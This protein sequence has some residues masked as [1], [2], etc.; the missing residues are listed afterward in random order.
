MPLLTYHML[1]R[2]NPFGLAQILRE[3]RR[4]GPCARGALASKHGADAVDDVLHGER[5]EQHAQ[6]T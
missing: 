2:L 3:H 6:Q 4:R 5:G 1:F